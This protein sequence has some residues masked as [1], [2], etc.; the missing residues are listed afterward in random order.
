MM[1]GLVRLDVP[2]DPAVTLD[3]AKRHL[4]VD[5]D[6]EDD[7][8]QLYLDA[9][10]DDVARE[11]S[12]ALAVAP[13]RFVTGSWYNCRPNGSPRTG[14]HYPAIVLPIAPVRSVESVKYMDEDGVEQTLDDAVWYENHNSTQ[15]IVLFVDGTTLPD[16]QGRDSDIT[17]AFTAGH[18]PA[19]ADVSGTDPAYMLPSPLRAAILLQTGHLYANRESV[20]VGRSANAVPLGVQRLIDQWRIYR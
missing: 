3:E 8:I 13:Y 16:L 2:A 18:D 6:L 7:T 1:T 12:R 9:A 19:R 11:T 5:H 15:G 10:T 17:V 20:V 14:F 4:R